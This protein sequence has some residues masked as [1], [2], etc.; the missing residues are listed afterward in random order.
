QI[1][2][3]KILLTIILMVIGGS[4]GSTA[5]GVKTTSFAVIYIYKTL[6]Y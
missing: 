6:I 4:P 2:L 3:Q 5:G 1:Q